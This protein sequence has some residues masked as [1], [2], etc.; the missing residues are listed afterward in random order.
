MRAMCIWDKTDEVIT[1]MISTKKDLNGM[2]YLGKKPNKLM[3]QDGDVKKI[4]IHKLRRLV[5][6]DGLIIT[7]TGNP[8]YDGRKRKL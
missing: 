1:K 7:F 3:L 5:S 2:T 6:F 8:I 4:G